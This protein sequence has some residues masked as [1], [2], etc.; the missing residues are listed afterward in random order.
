MD[1]FL[2]FFYIDK[3]MNCII[4][5][6][7][8]QCKMNYNQHFQDIF[9]E[10]SNLYQFEPDLTFLIIDTRSFLGKLFSNPYSFTTKIGL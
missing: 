7:I 3:K 6:S 8:F 10:K 1:F 2:R 4:C 9:N 5:Q